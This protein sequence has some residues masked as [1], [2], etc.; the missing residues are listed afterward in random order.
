LSAYDAGFKQ[1][2]KMKKILV[3]LVALIGFGISANAQ[4]VKFRTTQTVCNGSIS[5]R[6][7]FKSDATFEIWQNSR[8]VHTGTYT[9]RNSDELVLTVSNNGGTWRLTASI[10][11]G[12]TLSWARFESVR[13]EGNRCR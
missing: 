12:T 2:F 6:L 8:L 3:L 10:I 11:R 13:Y 4:S 5:E 7:V 1:I 9:I